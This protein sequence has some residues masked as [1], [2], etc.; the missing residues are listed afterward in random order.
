MGM[1][2]CWQGLSTKDLNIGPPRTMMIPQYVVT[3]YFKI[4][5]EIEENAG[6]GSMFERKRR[7]NEQV[8]CWDGWLCRE[9]RKKLPKCGERNRDTR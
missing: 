3:F 6:R 1:L 8:P 2:I 4:V 5:G 7:E 9:S